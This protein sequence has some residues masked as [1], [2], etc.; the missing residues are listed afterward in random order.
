MYI[1]G[2]L[3]KHT[4]SFLSH[5]LNV[6]DGRWDTLTQIPNIHK[7][8]HKIFIQFMLQT[9]ICIINESSRFLLSVDI[10]PSFVESN[11][12]SHWLCVCACAQNDYFKRLFIELGRERPKKKETA[13]VQ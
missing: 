11:T 3:H 7:P 4:G 13:S 8:N 9:S 5:S 6:Y 10:F 1:S 12:P 2:A